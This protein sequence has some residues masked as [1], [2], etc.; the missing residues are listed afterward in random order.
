VGR[1]LNWRTA[2]ACWANLDLRII[3]CRFPISGR[4]ILLRT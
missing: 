3:H 2:I 1:A 4:L